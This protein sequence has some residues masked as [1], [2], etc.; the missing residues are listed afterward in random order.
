MAFLIN[1]RIEYAFLTQGE[2][3]GL[4][5]RSQLSATAATCHY[6]TLRRGLCAT[7]W[8]LTLTADRKVIHAIIILDSRVL[9]VLCIHALSND[10]ILGRAGRA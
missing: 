9:S 1:P 2:P 5:D 7:K 3:G 4:G 10:S 6:G 8:F